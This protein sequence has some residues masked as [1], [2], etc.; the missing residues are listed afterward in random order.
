[1]KRE[2]EKWIEV[3]IGQMVDGESKQRIEEPISLLICNQNTLNFSNNVHQSER[4]MICVWCVVH[5]GTFTLDKFGM[6]HMRSIE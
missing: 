3:H 1:M 2:R 5:S 4:N 6:F